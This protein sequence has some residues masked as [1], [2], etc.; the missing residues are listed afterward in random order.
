MHILIKILL[1]L[2]AV[3]SSFKYTKLPTTI[4]GKHIVDSV[5]CVLVSCQRTAGGL[6]LS[7]HCGVKSI[8]FTP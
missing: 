1:N 4:V 5:L 6:R 8:N 2:N 7:A 3:M